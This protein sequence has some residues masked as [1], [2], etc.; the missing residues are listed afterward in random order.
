MFWLVSLI[1][2]P[3]GLL[4]EGE[5][6][7]NVPPLPIEYARKSLDGRLTL[8]I[9][10]QAQPVKTLWAK[11]AVGN[12]AERNRAKEY[13]QKTPPQITATYR[14]AFEERLRWVHKL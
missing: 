13:V 1:W 12:D 11:M 5:W 8:V 9:W 6:N 7:E 3:E 2:N 14:K 4:I 10:E